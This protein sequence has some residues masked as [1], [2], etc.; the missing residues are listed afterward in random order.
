MSNS[1]YMQLS[2]RDIVPPDEELALLGLF[3]ALKSFAADQEMAAQGERPAASMLLVEG[4]AARF[5][6]L[7][8]GQRQIMAIHVPGD[9]LDLHGF[10]LKTLA[11]GVCALSA[12]RVSMVS[13][14]MLRKISQEMPHLSRLLWL[15]TLIDGSVH[16]EWLVAMGRQS[17]EAQLAHLFCELFVRLQVVERTI[18]MS[19]N[20][21]LTQSTLA[22]VL[23]M[24]VVHAN[25]T[26]Q[27]LRT[28]N[29][30]A[31]NGGTVHISNWQGLQ[32]IAEFDPTYLC[33]QNEPR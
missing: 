18:G 32:D 33:L 11:H 16:R 30:I 3:G 25:R 4:Y 15:D 7:S 31:W 27:L 21:P 23:G 10:L 14:A 12:C 24:S 19:F 1:L 9:F 20:L 17:P 26:L 8:D 5:K 2:K 6:T 22:D 29:V 13:H 28:R